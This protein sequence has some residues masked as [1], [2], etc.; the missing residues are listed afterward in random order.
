M[1]QLTASLFALVSLAPLVFVS[2]ISATT[3]VRAS[4]ADNA[5]KIIGG[6]ETVRTKCEWY[7]FFQS[8]NMWP[9][10]KLCP[11]KNTADSYGFYLSDVAPS[12]ILATFLK[13]N[14]EQNAVLSGDFV[15]AVGSRQLTFKIGSSNLSASVCEWYNLF[16]SRYRTPYYLRCD[17]KTNRQSF[18]RNAEAD[19]PIGQGPGDDEQKARRAPDVE[20]F[21]KGPAAQQ[22]LT[23]KMGEENYTRSICEWHNFFQSFNPLPRFVTCFGKT[24]PESF[25]QYLFGQNIVALNVSVPANADAT[26]VRFGDAVSFQLGAETISVKRCALNKWLQSNVRWPIY[27]G[28]G[29]MSQGSFATADP[30]IFPK[31]D[32]RY[33]YDQNYTD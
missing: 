7:N 14:R 20:S 15:S 1:K 12:S 23:L 33:L 32:A 3:A 25:A 31:A 10:Y 30:K 24:P 2:S 21:L 26:S 5:V 22:P 9:K 6:K 13:L 8:A 27:R 19:F 4:G 17:G 18:G 16:Q 11:G 28:C 29:A